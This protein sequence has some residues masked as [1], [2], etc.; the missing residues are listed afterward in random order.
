MR[1]VLIEWLDSYGC[2]SNWEPCEDVTPPS[3]RCRSV[4]WLIADTAEY[5]TVVPH[6]NSVE[7]GCGDMTIPSCA[8]LNIRDLQESA[9]EFDRSPKEPAASPR[10][11]AFATTTRT[12]TAG[13]S[14][15]SG[16]RRALSS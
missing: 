15:P 7:H 12:R 5:K 1:L 16:R 3:L 4:G 14:S 6:L 13:G 2:G 10:W 9:L 11:C 8:V